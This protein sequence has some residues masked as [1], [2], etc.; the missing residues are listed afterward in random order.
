M[1]NLK[2]RA[3][4]AVEMARVYRYA[5]WRESSAYWLDRAGEL[6]RSAFYVYR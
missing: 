2:A 4:D 5:G 1:S 3:R 6:R